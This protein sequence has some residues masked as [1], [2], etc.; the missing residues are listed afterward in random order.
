MG[1]KRTL[2]GMEFLGPEGVRI[3]MDRDG[4]RIITPRTLGQ[5]VLDR[6]RVALEKY[7][8]CLPPEDPDRLEPYSLEEIGLFVAKTHALRITHRWFK[9]H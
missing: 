4:W 9:K 6:A 2:T 7:E 8:T 1:P 5:K 3:G